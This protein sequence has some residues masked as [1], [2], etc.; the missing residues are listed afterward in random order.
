MSQISRSQAHSEISLHEM[1]RYVRSSQLFKS[2]VRPMQQ[3][4]FSMQSSCIHS[5]MLLC[6]PPH[7]TAPSCFG[8]GACCI[9]YAF[10][11]AS[12]A[13]F[14]ATLTVLSNKMMAPQV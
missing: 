3:H 13:Y 5:D 1:L 4:A 6:W 2:C 11:S 8:V 12:G 14:P 7:S 10:T 9:A